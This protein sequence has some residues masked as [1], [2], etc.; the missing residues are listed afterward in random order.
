MIRKLVG[1]RNIHASHTY[2]AMQTPRSIQIAGQF[3]KLMGS[4]YR[5][6]LYDPR[7]AVRQHR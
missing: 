6:I 7:A 3:V 5:G 2:P 4:L 1:Y